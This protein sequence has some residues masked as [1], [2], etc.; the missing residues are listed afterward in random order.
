MITKAQARYGVGF[1]DRFFQI[2][3]DGHRMYLS[4][5][6]NAFHYQ[7]DYAQLVKVH[8]NDPEGQK[9]YSPAQCLGTQRLEI[10]GS[11]DPKYISTGF[12][13]RQNLTMRMNMRRFTRLTSAFSKKIDNHVNAVGLFYMHCNFCRI[14]LTLRVTSAVAAGISQHVWSLAEV[15]AMTNMNVRQSAA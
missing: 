9:R 1:P 8:G 14:R 15:V 13:E 10:V 6:P 7:V 11:P 12:V 3:T 4:T 5:V 2:T